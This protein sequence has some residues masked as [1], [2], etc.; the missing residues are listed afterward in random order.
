MTSKV[1][2]IVKI[3]DFRR[4]NRPA[5]AHGYGLSTLIKELIGQSQCS[6][7]GV[8]SSQ[9]VEPL[10]I[11]SFKVDWNYRYVCIFYELDHVG[12][13]G[14]IFHNSTS[15]ERSAV[16]SFL[17]GGYFT[18][19]E[20]TEAAPLLDMFHCHSYAGNAFA[21]AGGIGKRIDRQ[22]TILQGGNH[23]EDK[24]G[25]DLQVGTDCTYN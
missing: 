6:Q 2:K 25:E 17:Y 5:Y 22:K 12:W 7:H 8:N 20:K 24:V 16:L 15:F 11:F 13:P 9:K 10:A 23:G 19:G 21:L 3:G 18:C 14:D 1:V 4:E